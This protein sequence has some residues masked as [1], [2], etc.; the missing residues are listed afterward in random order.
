MLYYV[1][2]KSSIISP[3]LLRLMRKFGLRFSANDL[4]FIVDSLYEK[5]S[6]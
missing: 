5:I 2:R 3:Q 1:S 6:L 4:Q